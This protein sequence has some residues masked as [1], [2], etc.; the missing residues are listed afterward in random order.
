MNLDK[1]LIDYSKFPFPKAER[2]KLYE[3]MSDEAKQQVDNIE[4]EKERLNILFYQDVFSK[5][6]LYE[7]FNLQ[8]L[9]ALLIYVEQQ[10][11]DYEGHSALYVF[12]Y[13]TLTS[14]VHFIRKFNR[15]E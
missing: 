8:Q 14:L 15:A 3:E 13:D 11:E 5:L 1:Y 10:W 2:F 6:G 4:N 9:D 12:K 7:E